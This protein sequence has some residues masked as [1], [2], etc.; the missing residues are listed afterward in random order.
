MV[1]HSDKLLYNF[2]TTTN[3]H[4]RELSIYGRGG[5]EGR[6]WASQDNSPSHWGVIK[7]QVKREDFVPP[8][9][10]PPVYKIPQIWKISPN[11]F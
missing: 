7:N 10:P 6:G 1:L 11:F 8:P 9:P 2:T 5:G 3:K 4:L